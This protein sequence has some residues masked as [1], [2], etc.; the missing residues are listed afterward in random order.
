MKQNIDAFLARS[1]R[2]IVR[3]E[4]LPPWPIEFGEAG[5]PASEA[6]ARQIFFHGIAL[7]LIEADCAHL[8]WPRSL[9]ESVGQE[10]RLQTFWEIDH[11]KRLAKLIAALHSKG[12]SALLIKGSA[13]AYSVYRNPALR[14][15]GDSDLLI[16]GIGKNAARAVLS[17][18]GFERTGDWHPLQE[19]WIADTDY[20]FSH[21]IDLHWQIKSSA[22]VSARL[23]TV[24]PSTSPVELAPLGPDARGLAPIDNL[25]LTAIN[26]ASH[27]I[28]GYRNEDT[29]LFEGD[30]LIWAYDAHLIM[31][32]MD[33]A[34]RDRMVQLARAAGCAALVRD[35]L[36]FAQAAL[37]APIEDD[38]LE[39]LAGTAG[40]ET[41]TDYY[42]GSDNSSRL[43]DDLSASPDLAMKTRILR[44]Q[45]LPG[46][47]FL[48]ERF[49]GTER[50]PIAILWLRRILA[51]LFGCASGAR[52]SAGIADRARK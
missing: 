35:T 37:G 33:S 28:F 5:E 29:V 26:R 14:R 50:W 9:V 43:G 13:L 51:R 49:P 23:G 10:A 20:G 36:Q 45:I 19:A 52:R 8:D 21:E 25:L 38:I 3:S 46:R 34:Q 47:D 41:I 4:A 17:D 12:A 7:L 11:R 16:E 18:C 48:S 44:R 22:L 2:S 1:M 40:E 30:R 31:A 6:V 39:A 15:R 27:V 24:I 32:K 42:I